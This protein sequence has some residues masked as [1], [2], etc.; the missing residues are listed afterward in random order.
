MAVFPHE[1]RSLFPAVKKRV[2]LNAAASSPLAVPVAAAIEAHLQDTVEN[3]DVH[4]GEWLTF[5][6]RLREK[7]ARLIGATAA[8]VA[9]LGSTSH[10]F[11][12][13]AHNWA[14]R[15]I[16]RVLTLEGEFPSSTLPFLQAGLALQVVRPKADGSTTV[17]QLAEAL[18]PE[19]GAVA[20]SAVQFASGFRVDLGGVARLCRDRGL[21]FAVN[22]AQALGQVPLDVQAL[23]CEFLAA[24][25]HKWLMGGYGTGVFFARKGTLEGRQLPWSGWF[26]PPDALRWDA[27]AG[28]Q[29]SAESSQGFVARGV[30]IRPEPWALEAGGTSW[31]ALF[32]LGAGVELLDSVGVPQVLAHNQKL[33][34]VLR[35]GLRRRGFSPNA[36]DD[37]AGLSG[38]C[39]VPVA[40]DLMAAVRALFK[41]GVV[42]SPRGGG[43]RLSTHVFNDE[44]DVGAALAAFDRVGLTPA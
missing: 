2:Y 3:G 42:T 5:R 39:V 27:F 16:R 33:Q 9:F 44:G 8:E 19:V 36:P 21:P 4:F 32:G 40:G 43:V 7:V 11:S 13:V 24:P 1:V 22:A 25:S 15:G 37:D 18:G 6:D 12:A 28:A 10:G 17:E 23:G 29:R 14:Q 30:T 31:A 41:E 20:V 26:S 34:R 38:I 35:A